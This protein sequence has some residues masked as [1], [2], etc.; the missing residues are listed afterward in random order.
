MIL[1]TAKWTCELSLPRDGVWRGLSAEMLRGATMRVNM[2]KLREVAALV[3]PE[4]LMR[5]D[6]N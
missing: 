1:I 3:S 2:P 4:Y 6:K 5:K